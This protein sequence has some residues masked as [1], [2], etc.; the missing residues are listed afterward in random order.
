MEQER[1]EAIIQYL[2]EKKYGKARLELLTQNEVDIA[3]LL[4][5]VIEELGMEK[6]LVLFRILPKDVSVDVFS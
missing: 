1:T 2:Q 5:E 4:E 3:E 6:A